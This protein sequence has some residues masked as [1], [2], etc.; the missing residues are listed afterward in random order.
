[1]HDTAHLPISTVNPIAYLCAEFGFDATLPI[2][3][4]GLGILA[5]DT[6]KEAADQHF[7]MVGVGLLYR[8]LS[9]RQSVNE[10]GQQQESDWEFDPVSCGLEHVYLDGMPLFIKV[11]MTE[12]DVWLRVWKKTFSPEVTLYLLDSN[13]DQNALPERSL[14]Q[15]LYSGTHELQVKQQLILGVGA[16]K[17]L[18]TLGIKP[19]LYHCNEGRPA[20]A[21]W[22]L[23]RELMDHHKVNFASAKALARD[24]MVYTNHTLVAAGNMTYSMD[25]LRVMARYYAD[26]M[27]VPVD[28]L[29]QLGIEENRD[30]FSI[31]RFAL[32]VSRKASGVSALHTR[33][34]EQTWPEYRWVNVTN[35][36]HFPTW[37]SPAIRALASAS[38][39]PQV[40]WDAHV[41]AKL[42]LAQFCQ[43]HTGYTY[44]PQR[45]VITWAR[46]LA[47]YKQAG[48]L[49][50][51]ISRLAKLIKNADR[52]IQLLIAGKA[53]GGDTA[54]KAL[55]QSIIGYLKHELSGN[56]LYLPNYNIA[57]AQQLVRGSDVWLNTPVLGQE[58]CG[59]S[60]MKAASNGVLQCTVADGWAAEVD[61]KDAGYVLDPHH[62]GEH[63]LK[64]LEQEIVPL[65][66]TR[67]NG[68]PIAWIERMQKT[69][70]IATGYSAS[71]MLKEY[72]DKLYTV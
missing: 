17:L 28:E 66:Y 71:R 64:T 14:T 35:G 30:A 53:H 65:Y 59:T 54:G 1:M 40:L 23:I 72:Q 48:L 16:V 20:F 34:S 60:G 39:E 2:Y 32:N 61:W 8:G 9:M 67:T 44:D 56:A 47:G 38:P 63:L 45:L 21:H 43:A 7:P 62:T 13:T 68:L 31:T 36:V 57:V 10:E 26:K 37:Q 55:L 46:R 11:H 33:L 41:K 27:N 15:I 24:K 52:P 49:F 18:S 50:S 12:V 29:V 25:L 69:L 22:Q 5:G 3:A 58:A 42:E 51:D 6:L 70:R 4:G 19:S